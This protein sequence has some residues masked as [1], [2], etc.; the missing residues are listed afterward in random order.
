MLEVLHIIFNLCADL[1]WVQEPS[2]RGAV[3]AVLS[4][5]PPAAQAPAGHAVQPLTPGAEKQVQS[6]D[7]T[8]QEISWNQ[9]I[10]DRKEKTSGKI[11]QVSIDN[12]NSK[13]REKVWGKIKMYQNSHVKNQNG[14]LFHTLV[15]CQ[16][17]S[18]S[19]HQRVNAATVKFRKFGI[20]H[21]V[22]VPSLYSKAS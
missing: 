8:F 16:V 11:E 7:A 15:I 2:R 21:H 6:T 18:C 13:R 20:V 9:E 10:S 12:K 17:C 19:Y 4:P 22:H 5:V 1:A 14:N 3:A